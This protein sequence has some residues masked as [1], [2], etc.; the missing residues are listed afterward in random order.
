MLQSLRR[1]VPL[2]VFVA[3]LL[4]GSMSMIRFV[5]R[6]AAPLPPLPKSPPVLFPL[7]LPPAVHSA[8]ATEIDI[9]ALRDRLEEL[10]SAIPVHQSSNNV[11][12]AELEALQKKVDELRAQL[13]T[14]EARRAATPAAPSNV[15]AGD[16]ALETQ[17]ADDRTQ[18]AAREQDLASINA[19]PDSKIANPQ[20]RGASMPVWK[21]PAPVE[22]SGNRIAPVDRDFFHF[23]LLL[24]SS[25]VVVTRKH[26]GETIAE[27]QRPDSMFAK[28]LERVRKERCYVSCLLNGDSFEAFFAVRDMARRAGVDVSWEP[29]WTADGHVAITRVRLIRKA[30]DKQKT[31]ALPEIVH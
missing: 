5:P 23:P 15:P 4:A 28:F 2:I 22:L 12:A 6:D 10:R 9:Q 13:E 8:P 30:S 18:V 29:A 16:D 19:V 17:V 27:A 31:V 3:A 1:S 26:P 14:L 24:I 7:V 21:L 25:S 11:T 20:F